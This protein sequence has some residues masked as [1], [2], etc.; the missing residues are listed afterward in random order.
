LCL[1]FSGKDFASR[2][3]WD[4]MSY[5]DMEWGLGKEL[6]LWKMVV[7]NLLVGKRMFVMIYDGM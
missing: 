1:T 5:D 3:K 7:H 4:E 2:L 6:A